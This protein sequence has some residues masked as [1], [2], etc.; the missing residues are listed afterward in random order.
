MPQNFAEWITQITF[1]SPRGDFGFLKDRVA[2]VYDLS[3]SDVSIPSRGFWF[4][5]EIV[6]AI[7]SAATGVVR[8]QSPR[9]DF[10][11]LKVTRECS[12]EITTTRVS[13]P[14]RGFWF[15]EVPRFIHDRYP[16]TPSV[17]IPSRGFWFFEG[18]DER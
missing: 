17:S 9:G 6:S 8:F 1:Q 2:G 15:F 4:F 16:A 7:T 12:H 3:P 11:F 14:S 18:M 5:E 13:I 10:G